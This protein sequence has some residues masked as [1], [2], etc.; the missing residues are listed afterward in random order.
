MQRAPH[1]AIPYVHQLLEKLQS[2]AMAVPCHCTGDKLRLAELLGLVS[3]A[4]SLRRYLVGGCTAVN[5]QGLA[6]LGRVML[7]VRNDESLVHF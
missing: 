3:C 4:G 2:A 7:E 5:S 1:A 6:Q